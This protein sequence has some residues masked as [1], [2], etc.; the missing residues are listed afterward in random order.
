MSKTAST[1]HLAPGDTFSYTMQIG[2]DGRGGV[3]GLVLIDDVPDVLRLIAVTPLEPTKAGDPGWVDCVVSDR[4]PTGYGGVITCELD[5]DLGA[6]ERAPDVL[7][8]VQLSPSAPGGAIVNTAKATAYELPTLATVPRGGTELTTLALQD[9]AMV[10]STLAMTGASP[11]LA[12]QLSL[13][14]LVMGGILTA[15]RRA[16]PRHRAERPRP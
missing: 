2:N 14:L 8:D 7:L 9:S 5:R 11:L 15:L 3:T 4:L 13:A 1:A 10:M 16:M 6:G 12:A